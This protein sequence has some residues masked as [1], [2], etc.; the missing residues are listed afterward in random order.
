MRGMGSG[1]GASACVR[2]TEGEKEGRV[3]PRPKEI[4]EGGEVRR[5]GGP[6]GAGLSH[7]QAR[8]H[9]PAGVS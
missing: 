2:S 8:T 3:R 4:T 1:D 5:P 6:G 7:T 9:A